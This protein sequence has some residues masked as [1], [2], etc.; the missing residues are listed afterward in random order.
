MCHVS[1]VSNSSP[2][3][4]KDFSVSD[5]LQI[6]LKEYFGYDSFRPLQREII[7]E[8]LAGRDAVALLPT[9][10]GKSLC[11]QLPALVRVGLTLVI[12]PLI[13]LMKDQV[14]S[15]TEI[16]I[17]AAFLN[18]SL[19]EKEAR[20]VW[21]GLRQGKYKILYLSP[22]RLMVEGM[23]DTLESLLLE[24]IAVDEAHCISSWGHDFR[25]EYRT[26]SR[27]RDRFPTIPILA[28][29][30]TATE[31]V[32]K[33]IT[34][35]LQL[36][37]PRLFV[38]SFNRPNLSYRIIPRAEP[39]R[40]IEEILSTHKE[41]SV[42][43]YCLSRART[44][45]LAE[46][47]S[48]KGHK[49]LAYHAGLTAERR[50]SLQDK[51]LNDETLI[52]VATVAF[53]MGVNK[54]DI[55]CVIHH[56]LPKNL[57]SYYQET[58][59]AG[60]DG[61]PSE[62]V[63]LYNPADSAKLYSFIEQV[64]DEQERSAARTQLGKLISYAESTECRR[65][66]ILRY[67]GEVYTSL[68][69]EVLSACGAC[70][71]CLTPREEFDATDLT[72]RFLSCI[73]RI[74]QL[75]GFSVGLHHVVDV[76][77][78]VSSEKVVKFG[79]D[80]LSTFGIGKTFSQKSW[81][82]YGREIISRGYVWIDPE[83]YNTLHITDRGREVLK[84]RF[85]VQLRQELKTSI[86][87]TDKQLAR[88]RSLKSASN[89]QRLHYDASI[90]EKLRAWR[91]CVA[92]EKG[93][94]AFMIFADSTLQGISSANPKTLMQLRQVSGVGDKKLE[95]YGEDILRVLGAGR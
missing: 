16:G 86:L 20:L 57:E 29:T 44:E 90:F 59:R 31:R 68:S 19:E 25:P 63:L 11:Y 60:R 55:R 39:L 89:A 28:L 56:D 33:D 54:P 80:K 51:F 66:Q 79:H 95:L 15:L 2:E 49:A 40:Q 65:I 6:F 91:K 12:S 84:S 36:R 52:M 14:D 45:E 3:S 24:A 27:L 32:R 69:G 41:E 50:S 10:G 71:N 47:L 13:A 83:R 46:A 74:E 88:D 93:I 30:A 58:G 38:A 17:P 43:I 82:Y 35:L 62:C 1:L 70:D 37:E 21:A 94:P 67:F 72:Q 87:S 26:L 8:G 77:R 4:K 9:G 48:K 64:G 73:I 22:E 53:G 42:I 18:S 61:L 34:Q 76:L 23:L 92:V 7:D 78:G 75:G 5:P 81:I 85:A